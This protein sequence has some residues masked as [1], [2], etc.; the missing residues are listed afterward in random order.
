MALTEDSLILG[1]DSTTAARDPG[2]VTGRLALSLDSLEAFEVS[3]GVHR[4][5]VT[6][7]LV[8][9][10]L[11]S[12]G[13]LALLCT[14]IHDCLGHRETDLPGN[15]AVAI[16]MASAGVGALIGGT[17]G[18]FVRG[19]QWDAVPLDQLGRER[20][21]PPPSALRFKV[22]FSLF[23]PFPGPRRARSALDR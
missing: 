8:G 22:G 21:G 7:V 14:R 10:I 16:M 12:L 17:L 11:A 6:G 15:Q 4:N 5:V 1:R 20:V 19:E 3:R 18:F 23:P 9:G 2:A 13:G